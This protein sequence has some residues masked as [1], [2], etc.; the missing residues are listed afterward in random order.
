[1]N[2][3]L[4]LS[5]GTGTRLGSDKPKQYLKIGDKPIISYCL[6]TFASHPLIDAVQIVAD[7]SWHKYILNNWYSEKFKGYSAPGQNR[8]LSIYSGLYDIQKYAVNDDVVIIHDAARPN[9][10]SEIISECI[11]AIQEHDGVIPVL[12]MKDTV[13]L[14]KDGDTVSSLISR[15]ELFAGQAPEAFKLGKYLKANDMLIPDR[16]MNIN[17]S[18]EPAVIAGM[19]IV[20]IKGDENNFKITTKIDFERFEKMV[21]K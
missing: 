12:P 2:I 21:I 3:A 19:N 14:S 13:Y 7:N 6:E 1:M 15:E 11:E 8:Q 20:M 4:I 5:G 10:S 17:G 18:T 9:V 16:I